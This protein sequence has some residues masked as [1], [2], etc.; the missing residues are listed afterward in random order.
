MSKVSVQKDCCKGCGLCISACPKGVLTLSRAE[1]NKMGY[2]FAIVEKPEACIGC[3][4]CALM[5]PDC[6]L[7]VE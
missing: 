5:C 7:V 2:N 1:F 4:L 3:A 6:A